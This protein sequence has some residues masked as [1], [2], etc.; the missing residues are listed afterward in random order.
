MICRLCCKRLT[1][2]ASRPHREGL[3][4]SLVEAAACGRPIV[5]TDVPGC[6]EV[7]IDGKN[8]L[9]VEPKDIDGLV[10]AIRQLVEQ[11][12]LRQRMGEQGRRHAQRFDLDSV[13]AETI[14][15]YARVQGN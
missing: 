1:S 15:L 3:P 13:I 5:T 11:K 12:D 2:C 8:G 9:L 4:K 6:R 14:G 7:V 10:A